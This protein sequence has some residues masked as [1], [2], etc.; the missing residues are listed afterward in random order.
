MS[1][2]FEDNLFSYDKIYNKSSMPKISNGINV[3]VGGVTYHT[4]K[5]YLNKLLKSTGYRGLT[6]MEA[7]CNFVDAD[8]KYDLDIDDYA[9]VGNEDK[10]FIYL[11]QISYHNISRIIDHLEEFTKIVEIRGDEEYFTKV[12]IVFRQGEVD[13]I[14]QINLLDEWIYIYAS[15]YKGK[16]YSNVIANQKLSND[17]ASEFIIDAIDCSKEFI[18]DK[19]VIGNNFHPIID[20]L[21]LLMSNTG[22][23]K[24]HRGKFSPT[25]NDENLLPDLFE[26]ISELNFYSAPTK[27]Y[28]RSKL[29]WKKIMSILSKCYIASLGHYK[30]IP[31][32][33]GRMIWSLYDFK[34]SLRI[35]LQ[36]LDGNLD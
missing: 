28:M 6:T 3:E 11:K 24:C 32:T 31:M 14:A 5:D 29:S 27:Y 34:K 22:L 18:P 36:T 9:I 13:Y 7:I 23:V 21:G 30:E 26:I 1:Q 19:S 8:K 35:N 20:S 25:I 16:I 10:R 4:C 33:F 2:L 15:M 12:E 17:Y